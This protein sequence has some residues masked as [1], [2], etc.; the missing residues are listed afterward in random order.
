M[1]TFEFPPVDADNDVC[2]IMMLPS[3]NPE[4]HPAIANVY[5][6]CRLWA[7]PGFETAVKRANPSRKV[8]VADLDLEGC[9][10]VM[11]GVSCCLMNTPGGHD[12]ELEFANNILQAAEE[13]MYPTGKFQHLIFSSILQPALT[14]MGPYATGKM[15]IEEM[16]LESKVPYTIAHVAPQMDEVVTPDHVRG[17]RSS[18]ITLLDPSMA[19]SYISR[20]DLGRAMAKILLQRQTHFYATYQL[21]GTPVPLNMDQIANRVKHILHIQME[22]VQLFITDPAEK[23]RAG[24]LT[25]NAEELRDLQDEVGWVIP[26]LDIGPSRTFSSPSV[27]SE[28][29]VQSSASLAAIIPPQDGLRQTSLL[30]RHTLEPDSPRPTLSELGAEDQKK[31]NEVPQTDKEAELFE[32]EDM[33]ITEAEDIVVQAGVTH[34]EQNETHQERS[35]RMDSFAHPISAGPSQESI[36]VGESASSPPASPATYEEVHGPPPAEGAAGFTAAD[37]SENRASFAG[38]PIY[39]NI[40]IERRNAFSTKPS[41]GK[42]KAP[43]SEDLSSTDKPEPPTV[44]TLPKKVYAYG[45]PNSDV[46]LL[47]PRL[48]GRPETAA[49]II[50]IEYFNKTGVSLRGNSNSLRFVMKKEPEGFDG[51]LTRRKRE[52]EQE[53]VEL[54]REREAL[55][56]EELI[57]SVLREDREPGPGVVSGGWGG[58][59]GR[60]VAQRRRGAGFIVGATESEEERLGEEEEMSHDI[61][62]SCC[63]MQL[64]DLSKMTKIASMR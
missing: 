39:P 59:L 55:V 58:L 6:N 40:S 9:R 8:V 35:G 22:P 7:P 56:Q 2:L 41:K 62:F 12:R 24:D 51:F 63:Y 15:K 44:K 21:V 47:D 1:N 29:A 10:E 64:A 32:N 38:P 5:K 30:R 48:T 45:Q 31:D 33:T 11:K 17:N 27:Q 26:P 23:P 3:K 46:L 53:G 19:F 14:G 34:G 13:N 60:A 25:Y 43:T 61:F 4:V 54:E 37:I 50:Y 18:L 49:E 16:I 20:D 42:G 28:Q 36:K 57:G 52:W